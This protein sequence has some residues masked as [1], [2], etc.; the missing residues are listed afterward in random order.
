[1]LDWVGFDVKAPFADYARITGVPGSGEKARA[2]LSLLVGSGVTFELRTTVHPALLT[3]DDLARLDAD[4]AALG[5]PRSRLQPFRGMG[6]VDQAL[7]QSSPFA[8]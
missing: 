4:L 3:K 2:S 6:C 1:M 7:L 5:A 8:P